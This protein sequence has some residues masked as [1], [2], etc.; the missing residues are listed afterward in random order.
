[1]K[2]ALRHSRKLSKLR[3]SHSFSVVIFH[4]I[5]L[6]SYSRTQCLVFLVLEVVIRKHSFANANHQRLLVGHVKLRPKS[7]QCL[8][9]L[10]FDHLLFQYLN[11][12]MWR[13]W[14]F[15]NQTISQ[16]MFLRYSPVFLQMIIAGDTS[17]NGIP[18]KYQTPVWDHSTA[19]SGKGTFQS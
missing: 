5:N 15:R 4:Q 3:H 19:R 14:N 10:W 13:L 6:I 11:Q 2:L 7:F 16:F 9:I 18:F 12:C 8:K 17:R 1:M